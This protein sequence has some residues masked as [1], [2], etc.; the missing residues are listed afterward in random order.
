MTTS[1]TEALPMAVRARVRGCL[2]PAAIACLLVA[3]AP[4]ASTADLHATPATLGSVFASAQGGD[5]IHLASGSYGQFNGGAKASTVTLKPEPGATPTLRLSLVGTNNLRLDG[6]TISGAYID[7]TRNLAIVNCRFTGLTR[8]DTRA[9]IT[10]AGIL[11]DNDTFYGISVEPDSYEGR[12][13]VRGYVNTSPVGVTIRN[14]KFGQGGESDGVQIIG[15]AYGVQVGPGNEFSNIRQGS[16]T[17]HCDPIQLYDETHSIVI[18]NYFHH[19]STAIMANAGG[20]HARIE[21]NVFDIDEYPWAFFGGGVVGATII[22]NT[23]IGGAIRLEAGSG[24][25]SSGNIV[26]DNISPLSLVS[27][28]TAIEDYNLVP[29]GQGTGAHDLRGTPQFVGGARPTTLAGFKLKAGTLGT[30]AA[31]DGTDMGAAIGGGSVPTNQAP[32]VSL[33]GPSSGATFTAP[34]AIVLTATAAD[35]DGT[36]ARVEFHSGS[37]LIGG[38]ATA[39][40]AV[41]WNSVAAGSY[42]LTAKAYDTLGASRTS[43]AV[44]VTV[45]AAGTQ[46]S[47]S[48]WSAG[49]VPTHPSVADASAVEVGVKFRSDLAGTITAVRFYKGAGNTGT[50]TGHLWS[51]SGALLGSVT[52]TG[53]SATGWQQATFASPIAIAANTTYVASYHA[54]AGHY[55][56]DNGFFTGKGVDRAPLHALADGVDG[57]NGVYVYG[58]SSFPNQTWQGSNYWVDVV[59]SPSATA[60]NRAVNP[61]FEADGAAVQAISGWSTWP[62]AAGVDGDADYTES[63]ATDRLGGARTGTWHGTHWK[64][65]AYEVYTFQTRT[66]LANG[67]Y[68]LSAWVRSSGGQTHAHLEAKDFGGTR[69]VATIPATS[70]WTR[71]SVP[72]VNVTNGRC[73]IGFYSR[74]GANQWIHV[75]DVVFQSASV[76]SA[77]AASADEHE[78]AGARGQ[79]ADVAPDGG[80]AGCG[81][82]AG[83]AMLLGLALATR[84]RD[85]R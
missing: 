79:A 37:A 43:A 2:M 47:H 28:S 71:I 84:R 59:F 34:A 9:H 67:P 40:Y 16:F 25:P 76:G 50:H 70:T 55:A 39:P 8:V 19:N 68:S 10:N 29:A 66:G 36:I 24:G 17:A 11:F 6:L 33:T 49:S 30:T 20:S 61:G 85:Q 65:S 77:M 3:L 31:S 57:G 51:R 64:G 54:P 1:D 81:L 13:T 75:D 53:E 32:S 52:F 41:T 63:A 35:S 18:G 12:L 73:V 38:D 48:L 14:C 23:V 83:I 80:S 15:G 44:V 62:G 60:P 58:A 72:T 69:V 56:G 42:T 45:T 27:G 5:T 26:R 4:Q 7:A 82:G 21:G 46:S 74:A 22:H 78:A